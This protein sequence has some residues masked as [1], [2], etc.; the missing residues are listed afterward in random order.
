MSYYQQHAEQLAEQYNSLEASE[1]HAAWKHLLGSVEPGLACDIGAGSGRDANWLAEQ[2]WE[3]IAV[4][5]AKAMREIAMPQAHP[6]V[7]WLD[8]ELPKLRKLRE[9]GYRFNLILVSAVWMHLSP[10]Q[11][12]IG[13]R[14]LS[15]LLAAGGVLVITLRHESGAGVREARDFHEVNSGELLQ[16]ASRRALQVVHEGRDDDK[17]GRQA[18][19]WET[20]CFRLPDDG[21]GSLPLLRHVI[22]NDNKSASYKLGLIR[23]LVRIADGAPG[24]VLRRDDDWVELPFGAVGLYWLKLYLPLVINGFPQHPNK[25]R[26]YGFAKDDFQ[27]LAARS[28]FDLRVGG[29]LAGD[30]AVILIG[31]LA[32]ACENIRVMPAHYLTYPGTSEQVFHCERKAVRRSSKPVELNREF[33]SRFGTFRVPTQLWQTMGQFGAWL[34]PAVTNEWVSLMRGWDEARD[35]KARGLGTYMNA[36][37]WKQERRDTSY[38]RKRFSDITADGTRVSCTWSAA[39]LKSDNFAID[40]CFPWSR[41]FNNDL[42][43]LMPATEKVNGKKGDKLP[44]AGLMLNSRQRILE[45]WNMAF[46]EGELE[47][48]FYTEAE[49]ALPLLNE[50]PRE[51]DAVFSA[52]MLQRKKIKVNQ[53]LAEWQPSSLN[54]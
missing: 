32:A 28:Q 1:V 14:V 46:A 27:A 16:L 40:H 54:N 11:R 53:Q 38:V 49:A 24:L 5:P 39:R 44:T 22:V 3:V 8:D 42:W 19:K 20:L 35:G 6:R 4:E 36:L 25:N 50:S 18:V 47:S 34:E 10:N 7:S 26:G 45:W 52:V 37:Q 12:E 23:T 43:N 48:R 41:W 15:D 51:L 33:L 2:G 9:T 17:L 31:A 29:R 13:F 30:D 21:T